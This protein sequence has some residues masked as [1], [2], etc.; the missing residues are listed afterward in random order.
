MV[1]DAEP[2]AEPVTFTL[3]CA[4]CHQTAAPHTS[5]SVSQNWATLHLKHNPEHFTYR[6][7]TTRPYKFEP[8]AWL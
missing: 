4:V 2:D 5:R 7:I 1:P 3:Q 6:E 8:G